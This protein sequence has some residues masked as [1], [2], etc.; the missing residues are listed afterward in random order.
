MTAARTLSIALAASTAFAAG[1][2]ASPEGR[3][4]TPVATEFAVM[5]GDGNG[6]STGF[7]GEAGEERIGALATC[8][9]DGTL[10]VVLHFG[11]FPPGRPVQAAA[12]DAD[13]NVSRFGPVVTGGP[14]SGFHSP[15]FEDRETALRIVGTVFR[16]GTL[17]SNGHNSVW[18]RIPGTENEHARS[19][20]MRC[21][22][23]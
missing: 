17:L 22:N 19:R 9:N 15:L 7:V 5:G 4:T 1:G 2:P 14:R 12:R 21:G 13:G 6:W 8:R 23:E 18:N 20:L 11:L 3:L 10:Q 16:R